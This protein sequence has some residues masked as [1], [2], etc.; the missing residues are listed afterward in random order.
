M[1]PVRSFCITRGL[2]LPLAGLPEQVA[3]D[4]I[5][6][7]RSTP[8]VTVT[9]S[10]Y[11]GMKPTFAV[12]VGDRVKLGQRLFED[13][14]QPG[15]WHTSTGTGIVTDIRRG[16]KRAFIELVV[17]LEG[18]ETIAEEAKTTPRSR[19]QIATMNREDV[20]ECLVKSGLWTA[21][22]TRPMSRVPSPESIPHSL[23]VTAID[24]HPLAP[25]PN[26]VIAAH[27]EE[28][29]AGLECLVQ[30]PEHRVY[31]CGAPTLPVADWSHPRGEVAFFSGCHPAGL[32]GTHMHFIS[33]VGAK[34]THWH[35][36][37]Q[38]VIALGHYVLT[39]EIRTE[40]VVSLAGPLAAKPRLVKTRLGA[41]LAAVTE[42]EING[43]S[44]ATPPPYRVISGSVFG[45]R[46]A[47]STDLPEAQWQTGLG[48][49]H[50][51][52]TVV[53]EMPSPEFFGWL[54]P[55]FSKYSVSR[56]LASTVL[57]HGRLFAINTAQ[58]GGERAIFPV[59]A[60]DDVMPLDILPVFLFRALEIQDFDA[61]EQLGALELDEED[62]SLCTFVDPGKNDYAASLRAMLTLMAKEETALHH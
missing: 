37:Y 31:C 2:T 29:L 32:V 21:L 41:S 58:N 44:S 45:G 11:V 15:V 35:I 25:D 50:N 46:L 18:N 47:I 6:S 30:V 9:A 57:F 22:R 16:E 17:S 59:R 51:Q 60:L 3:Y 39:G 55:G 36:G 33:P 61:C 62:L 23:F 38:D 4:K 10:D 28:F 56:L 14:K 20:V 52:I 34:K 5:E 43:L 49:Y 53:E 24:T 19:S 27:R 7:A 12:S 54:T 1:T 42:G 8:T 13:K 40:R 26:I 48:R